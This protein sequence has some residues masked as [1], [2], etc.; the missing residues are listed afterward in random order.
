[1][2][3]AV[4]GFGPTPGVSPMFLGLVGE[5]SQVEESGGPAQTAR[6]ERCPT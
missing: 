5:P 2:L 1:M 4:V 3:K 6:V